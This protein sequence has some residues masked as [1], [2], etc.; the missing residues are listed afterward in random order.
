MTAKVNEDSKKKIKK[1]ENKTNMNGNASSASDNDKVDPQVE[2]GAFSNFRISDTSIQKLKANSIDYLFPIQSQTFDYVYDGHDVI[3]QARTGTGKTLSFVLPLVEK[4]IKKKKTKEGR[5]PRVLVLLPTRELAKQVY[6]DFLKVCGELSAFCFYGGVPYEPQE[7]AL[8]K[9]LDILVGTPGRI[10]DHIQKGNMSLQKAK[11]VVLDEVDQM[12]DM[13]FAESVDEILKVAY[14]KEDE[15]HKPQTLLFSATLPPWVYRTAQKYMKKDVKKVDL[16]G[17]QQIKTSTTV[18]HL[19]IKC[20]IQD[21]NSIIADIIQ[22]YSGNHGRAIVFCQTKKQADEL[23]VSASMKLDAHVLHGDIPQDKRELVLKSFRDSKYK[24][25]L[26]T[27]VAARGLDIPEVDLVVQ[28]S[29][30]KDTDAYIHR[31]GRTGRAG[32]SG[33]S[34]LFYS[35]RQESDLMQVERRA[36]VSFKRIGPPTT[37][38]IIK[39]YAKD[40]AR[41]LDNVPDETLDYFRDSANILIEERGAENAL[42]AALAVISKSTKIISRSLLSAKE[43]YVSF[44][45]RT[46][47]EIRSPGYLLNA[48]ERQVPEMSYK[49][50]E[51]RLTKDKKG[52]VLDVPADM[53]RLL[54]M[55]W[56]NSKHESLEKATEL[57]ELIEDNSAMRNGRRGYGGGGGGGGGGYG[58]GWGRD[59]NSRGGGGGGGGFNRGRRPDWRNSRFDNHG[60]PPK[61][62]FR[63]D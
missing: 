10:L 4:L 30:P 40:A 27:D 35:P 28:C 16:I 41:S 5:M 60:G 8:W 56:L 3:A 37:V 47:T 9:G 6:E 11:H 1:K 24:V 33:I 20:S 50:G 45:L 51:I 14:D 38:D 12:L 13:G 49:V 61:K 46:N 55:K 43:G 29:P 32:R 63:F 7:R 17:Q 58:G 39:T 21:R 19:A 26:T 57:P 15:G 22:V 52:G 44:V 36:G 18:Q 62:R 42:A 25:L 48:L 31:S 54:E 2:I 23:A 59:R 34:V 53:V